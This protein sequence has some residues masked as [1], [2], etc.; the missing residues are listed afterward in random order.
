VSSAEVLKGNQGAAKHG[1][2]AENYMPEIAES[3]MSDDEND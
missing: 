2:H 1:F 3:I